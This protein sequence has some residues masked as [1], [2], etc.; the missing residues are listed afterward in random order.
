MAIF[1][2]ATVVAP[3]VGPVIGGYLTEDLSWRWCFYINVPT[4]VGSILLLTIFLPHEATNRRPFDFLGFGSLAVAVAA[5]QLVLDRGPTKDWFGSRELCVEA[6]VAV[7]AFWIY[8]THTVTAEH[9]LFDPRLARDRNF[10]TTSIFGFF[11]TTLSYSSVTLLP[12]LMQGVLGYP[13]IWS[14]ILSMPRG[15]TIMAVL[16]VM[17]R[18]DGMIDRRL[19]VFLGLG[20]MTASFW[21][22]RSSTSPWAGAPSSGRAW[23]RGS[24]RG[25]SSCR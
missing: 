22:M 14:G 13:V 2:M 23:S 8:V 9:P 15:L 16:L 7:I 1:T 10:T 11:L 18:I 24:A 3:V 12:L 5:L 17:G 6:V 21:Q 19:L 4:G 20:L 25:S